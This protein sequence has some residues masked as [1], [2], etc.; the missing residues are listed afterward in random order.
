L[1]DKEKSLIIKNLV[2]Y[3]FDVWKYWKFAQESF[4][5]GLLTNKNIQLFRIGDTNFHYT[6]IHLFSTF[7]N[8]LKSI[9]VQENNKWRLDILNELNSFCSQTKTKQR[10]FPRN[11]FSYNFSEPYRYTLD[12]FICSLSLYYW[13]DLSTI[14]S[15][16]D[17]L[18]RFDEMY[19]YDFLYEIFQPFIDCQYLS[20][21]DEDEYSDL[22]SDQLSKKYHLSWEK[23]NKDRLFELF[24][25]CHYM[26]HQ[27][28]E[29][30]IEFRIKRLDGIGMDEDDYDY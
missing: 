24:S 27:E 15:I 13:K 7:E 17:V 2:Q 8:I 18:E 6:Q 28:L 25:S 1:E 20:S 3:L 11:R 9:F 5:Q 10:L 29:F 22:F 23:T 21:M 12:Q 19:L 16:A 4:S 14:I 26:V 30:A